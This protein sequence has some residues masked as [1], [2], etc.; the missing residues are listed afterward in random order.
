M[1]SMN[2]SVIS[3]NVDASK[4]TSYKYIDFADNILMKM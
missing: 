3:H 1:L 2:G 4:C